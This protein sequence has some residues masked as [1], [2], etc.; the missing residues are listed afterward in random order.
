MDKREYSGA[1]L[2]SFVLAFENSEKIIQK[3]LAD[4]G[5]DRIDADRWYDHAWAIAIFYK[6][7]EE[8][9]RGA[10]MEVGRRMIETATYPPGIDDITSLLASLGVAY[11]LNARGPD[12]GDVVCTFEDDHSA[13]LDWSA[14]GPCAL[15]WGILEGSCARY[16]V[17]ALIE[18][19]GEG[20]KDTGAATCIYHVS[21]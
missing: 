5:V 7:G 8:V 16:G 20:C 10:L 14:K 4:A 1:A 12:I 17:K 3:L 18:H 15:C 9:G 21:W 2:S 13:T 6:I 11:R 19:G